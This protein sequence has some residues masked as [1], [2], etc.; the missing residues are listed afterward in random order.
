MFTLFRVSTIIIIKLFWIGNC[1]NCCLDHGLQHLLAWQGVQISLGQP[2]QVCVN[3]G[4]CGMFL[5][6]LKMPGCAKHCLLLLQVF[7]IKIWKTFLNKWIC[8]YLQS[9][10]SKIAFQVLQKG[11]NNPKPQWSERPLPTFDFWHYNVKTIFTP[12]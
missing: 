6:E 8:S 3:F 12:K 2:E 1:W 5:D 10:F 7:P 11:R 9:Y 4:G